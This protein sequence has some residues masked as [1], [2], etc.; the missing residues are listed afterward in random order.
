METWYVLHRNY[1]FDP[2]FGGTA[3]CVRFTATGPELNGGYPLL[4]RFGNSSVTVTAELQSSPGYSAKN[5]VILKPDGLNTSFPV[6]DV[7]MTCEECAVMRF[8]YVNDRACCLLVPESQLGHPTTCCNFVFDLL[9][10]TS[11]KYIIYDESCS[12]QD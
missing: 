8:A 10:G 5:I 9:C 3:K 7:Y 12:A 11:P 4:I 1:K 6:Y 2:A